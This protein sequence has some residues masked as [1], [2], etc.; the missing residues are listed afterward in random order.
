METYELAHSVIRRGALNMIY[1]TA[2][3]AGQWGQRR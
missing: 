1:V 2:A 3:D